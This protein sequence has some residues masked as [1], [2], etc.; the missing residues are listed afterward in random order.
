M[1][2]HKPFPE[3][4]DARLMCNDP[5]ALAYMWMLGYLENINDMCKNEDQDDVTIDE[6][7]DAAVEVGINDGWD[8]IQR[9]GVFEGYQV[10]P[11]FWDKLAIL[12]EID[13]PEDNRN[14]FFTC[15]C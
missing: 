10:D 8:Y 3:E 15:S 13:I 14:S 2:G 12:K 11:L 4:F 5:V 7:L 9:G 6:L 1:S